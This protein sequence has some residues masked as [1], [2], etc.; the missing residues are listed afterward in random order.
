MIIK[1]K[2]IFKKYNTE[3][4]FSKKNT[5]YIGENGIGKSTSIKILNCILK[6]DFVSLLHY[7]FSEVEFV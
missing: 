5:I 2:G 1:I 4:D 7:Y 6:L 3:F